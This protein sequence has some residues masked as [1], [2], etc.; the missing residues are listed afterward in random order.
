MFRKYLTAYEDG[1]PKYDPYVA[2]EMAKDEIRNMVE[3]EK[4]F[5]KDKTK[6]NTSPKKA[7]PIKLD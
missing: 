7:A 3:V 5:F 4:G 2:E 1:F 6:L